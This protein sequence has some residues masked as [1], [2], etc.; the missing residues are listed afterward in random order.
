MIGRPG[1][2]AKMFSTL[3]A[4][5]VNIQMIS[6]S[7]VKVSCTVVGDECD[8]AIA[9]LCKAFQVTAHRSRPKAL[10]NRCWRPPRRAR[11]GALD[12][13]QAQVAIRQVPD[14]PGMAARIFHLLAE[15]GVSVDMIIQS[16]RCRLVNGHTTRDIAFTVAQAE[17]AH[18]R[19]VVESAATEWAAGRWW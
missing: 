16:Q 4:A 8:R 7:E 11:C 15:A 9:A 5:G 13:K 2:A 10:S 18:A 17:A 3:A 19:A 14:R 1:V 6:T 12:L